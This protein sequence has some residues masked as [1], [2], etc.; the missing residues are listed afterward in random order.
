MPKYKFLCCLLWL[1]ASA[2]LAGCSSDSTGEDPQVA[3]H[4]ARL[5]LAEEPAGTETIVKAR[6]ALTA[7]GKVV[8]L[9]RIAAGDLSPWDEGKAAFLV[10]DAAAIL[11]EHGHGPC[12]DDTCHFCKGK[13]SITDTLAI[14]QCQDDRGEVLPIDARTLL[15]VEEN[16]LVVV[17]GRGE[18]DELGNLVIAAEGIYIRR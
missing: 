13:T 11:D 4:R 9:G 3:V 17:C 16:Q 14:V 1:I 15:G 12:Q 6:Q 10:S 5:L 18:L 2:T 7:N 8:I